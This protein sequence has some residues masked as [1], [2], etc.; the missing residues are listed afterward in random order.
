MRRSL[1]A[2]L[3]LS[4][5][6]A[7]ACRHLRSAV[8]AGS[9]RRVI[10][11]AVELDAPTST[12]IS[13]AQVAAAVEEAIRASGFEASERIT[14]EDDGPYLLLV[15]T[16][17]SADQHRIRMHWTAEEGACGRTR[18]VLLENR[19]ELAARV[20]EVMECIQADDR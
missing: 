11:Y 8:G 14:V 7:P 17:L 10:E 6:T 15:G 20:R 16:A 5:V 13:R 3:L 9:D 2:V 19:G 18:D 1:T 12:A 4:L